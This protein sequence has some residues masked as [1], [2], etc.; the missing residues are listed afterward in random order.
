[1]T[2]VKSQGACGSCWAFSS[3][4]ALE[5]ANFLK[6]GN[7]VSLSE[8]HLVSCSGPY[9]PNGCGG[10]WYF[11]AF[12]FAKDNTIVGPSDTIRTYGLDTETNYPYAE[13][14][15]CV[16]CQAAAC[17]YSSMTPQS[18][19]AFVMIRSESDLMAAVA[20][21]GPISVA[22]SVQ[23]SF[24]YYQSGVYSTTDCVGQQVNHAVLVVGYGHD[25]A[26]GKDYWL[27]KNS[28]DTTFGENGYIRMERNNNN[29]CSIGSYG[30]YPV[31]SAG[32]ITT[33]TTAAAG[34]TAATDTTGTAGT[35]KTAGTTATSGANTSQSSAMSSTSACPPGWAWCQPSSSSS[36]AAPTGTTPFVCPQGWT[37]CQSSSATTAGMPS[38]T[39]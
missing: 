19:N 17:K 12:T 23:P 16:K 24:Q 18:Q 34:T 32:N 31:L 25:A 9:G 3:T 38:T 4:G 30:S 20:T 10:G 22:V 11:N 14:N 37:W 13:I 29:M 15:T 5:G 35:T 33:T 2:P 7:L 27:V 8:E 26:T 39:S 21:K 6:Y 28:W 1:V 36:S